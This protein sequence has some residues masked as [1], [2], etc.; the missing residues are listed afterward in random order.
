MV[1]MGVYIMVGDLATKVGPACFISFL[2]AG[3]ACAL[4][5]SQSN[6]LGIRQGLCQEWKI[7]HFYHI[8]V[9]F[10]INQI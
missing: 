2:I 3:V 8:I 5:G 9:S 7:I 4:S 10:L 6:Y 1:G